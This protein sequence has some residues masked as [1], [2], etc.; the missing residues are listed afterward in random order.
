MDP[1]TRMKQ[2]I[3]CI[4]VEHRLFR[5]SRKHLSKKTGSYTETASLACLQYY[6]TFFLCP[7]KLEKETL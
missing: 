5:S 4:R 7:I 6:V 2:R 1:E 3:D